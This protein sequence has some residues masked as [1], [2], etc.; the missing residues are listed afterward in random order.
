HIPQVTFVR[1]NYKKAL[2]QPYMFLFAF[3]FLLP[4]RVRLQ[5]IRVCG[6]SS[7][8]FTS[9]PCLRCFVLEAGLVE[10][11]SVVTGAILAI[12]A[13]FWTLEEVSLESSPCDSGRALGSMLFSFITTAVGG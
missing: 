12:A 3:G 5:I 4:W 9:R 13:V 6:S 11:S 10:A 8:L 2:W 1:A 7:R